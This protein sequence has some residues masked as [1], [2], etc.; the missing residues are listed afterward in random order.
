M[1]YPDH[2]TRGLGWSAINPALMLYEDHIHQWVPRFKS[3]QHKTNR[4]L[5]DHTHQWVPR[6]KS[7]QHKSNRELTDHI[8]QWVPRF[9]S[10]QR[11]SNRELSAVKSAC[12]ACT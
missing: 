12:S 9:K 4:E 10:A 6:C 8:H 5:S 1:M 2:L 11:K 3:A 7:A